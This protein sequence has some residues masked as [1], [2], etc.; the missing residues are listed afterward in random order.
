M[1]NSHRG[2]SLIEL[3]VGITIGVL[4]IT[5]ALGLV[6]VS[7]R[8]DFQNKFSQTAGE[9]NQE[10]IEQLTTFANADWHNIESLPRS[11]A[12]SLLPNGS[13]WLTSP[14]LG[15]TTITPTVGDTPYE[16]SF[17]IE[18]VYRTSLT[19]DTISVSGALDPSTLKI[20]AKTEWN[21][22]GTTENLTLSKYITRT[23]NRIWQQTDWSGTIKP[24]SVYN[25]S[26]YPSGAEGSHYASE[27]N[28]WRGA[29]LD[30]ND[31]PPGQLKIAS[32]TQNFRTSPGIGID[33]NPPPSYN[34]YAW[35]DVM[36]WFDF[37]TTS[38]PVIVTNTGLSGVV[39]TTAAP[40]PGTQDLV[41]LDCTRTPAGN[42]C[43]GPAG[44]FGVTQDPSHILHGYAW[45]SA[46]GWISFNSDNCDSEPNGFNDVA[47]GGDNTT[48][49]AGPAYKVSIGGPGVAS[50]SGWAWNDVIGWIS[51]NCANA[52]ASCL[53]VSYQVKTMVGIPSVSV[54]E[55]VSPTFDT[56]RTNGAAFN[57]ITWLGNTNGGTVQFKIATS[58]C[59][60]GADNYPA[61]DSGTWSFFG[62]DSANSES[63]YEPSAPG[64]PVR[65]TRADHNNKRYIRYTIYLLSDINLIQSPVVDDVLINWSR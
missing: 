46:I 8:I 59:A 19:D 34:H 63:Y 38:Y 15:P 39:S 7:L 29:T 41:A 43:T 54:G 30:P 51:F 49:P 32:T 50:F 52:G 14:T 26:D 45:S 18:D 10:L 16:V 35:N 21:Q 3:L 2:Q 36:G 4:F 11:T 61:C 17:V 42:I 13:G 22:S 48:T 53:N 33:N 65:I 28:I 40:A 31:V 27:T 24:A 58:D 64:V 37:V 20:T 9:L 23:Q 62:P 57:T 5:A 44:A 60:N 6:T 1:T 47:C 55:L 56:E 12:Y 25:S